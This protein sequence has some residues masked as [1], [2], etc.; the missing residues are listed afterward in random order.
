M[1]VINE[2]LKEMGE[3]IEDLISVAVVGMDGLVI[4][5]YKPEGKESDEYVV[6]YTSATLT[7]SMKGLYTVINGLELGKMVDNLLSTEKAHFITKPLGDA[8]VFLAVVAK[9]GVNLG[10]IRYYTK[11]YAQKL[12]DAL[13]H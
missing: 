13:P 9:R 2:V 6:E 10:A 8:S 4:A 3:Q 5:D 7:T 11:I 12:W 1:A